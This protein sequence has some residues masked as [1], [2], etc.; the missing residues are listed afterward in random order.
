MVKCKRWARVVLCRNCALKVRV[1]R[2]SV[3]DKRASIL[4]FTAVS[5]H[6]VLLSNGAV[7]H[8]R[9]IEWE[10]RHSIFNLKLEA[11]LVKMPICP[12]LLSSP[13]CVAMSYDFL[14]YSSRIRCRMCSVFH[15]TLSAVAF[16]INICAPATL[17][18]S[19][20]H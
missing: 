10:I 15:D 17:R 2:T 5:R 14:A 4:Y 13:C 16:C 1:N 18:I 3:V 11:R 8:R 19:D 12:S 20:F 7:V 6:E 9:M